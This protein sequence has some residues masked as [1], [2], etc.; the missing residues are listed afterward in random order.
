MDNLK[1]RF[2]HNFAL[3]TLLSLALLIIGTIL[4]QLCTLPISYLLNKI[5][6]FNLHQSFYLMFLSLFSCLFVSLIFCLW[7]RFIEKQPLSF[8][9]FVKDHWLT[10]YLTG[11]LIGF[12]MMSIVVI[13]L[14]V[15][16]HISLE[17]NNIQPTGISS[18]P[19]ILILLIGWIIQGASE[20]I[21]TR[22]YLMNV[23][24]NKYNVPVALLITSTLF[25]L[26][27]LGNPGVNAIAIINIILV[28]LF[29]GLCTIKTNNLWLACG[30]HS[31]WNF[32]QGNIFGFEVS[33]IDTSV[34]SLIDLNLKGNTLITGGAFGPEAGLSSTIVLILSI[35]IILY[36]DKKGTF[37]KVI[38]NKSIAK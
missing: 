1:S 34:G 30:I 31:A 23:L 7:V 11:L 12:A 2:W 28:G 27:H 19:F 17:K 18:L 15:S 10:K 24:K 38:E 22:G 5:S 6:I 13:I 32:A 25:G 9:G 33:G 21:V 8:I 35:G 20:E 14:L 16:G 4:G 36:L 29:F 3:V 37:Q 26:L